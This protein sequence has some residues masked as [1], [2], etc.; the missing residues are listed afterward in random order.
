[1]LGK[2]DRGTSVDSVMLGAAS[3]SMPPARTCDSISGSPPSWLLG[4]TVTLSRPDDCAPIARAAS[5]NRTVRGWVSGVLTPSLNSNSAAALA[6]LPSTVVAKAADVDPSRPLRVIFIVV[7]S[8]AHWRALGQFRSN[9]GRPQGAGELWPIPAPAALTKPFCGTDETGLKQTRGISAANKAAVRTLGGSHE[10]LNS[11]GGSQYPP[12]NR[13][14]CA[15]RRYRGGRFW[16]LCPDQF[17]LHPDRPCHKG[18]QAGGGDQ[19]GRLAGPLGPG[20]PGIWNAAASGRPFAFGMRS[21]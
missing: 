21:R 19:L 14:R 9:R 3:N 10:P 4:N 7:A 6:D 11:L 20:F 2:P 5:V 13:G 12:E 18:R 16:D 15:H 8:R 1:M 17:G